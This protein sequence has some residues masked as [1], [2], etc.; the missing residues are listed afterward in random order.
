MTDEYIEKVKAEAT[1]ALDL[2]KE[3]AKSSH[4]TISMSVIKKME[5]SFN[6]GEKLL[7]LVEH[8]FHLRVWGDAY[9]DMK[10]VEELMQDKIEFG[11]SQT[12]MWG[13]WS[14]T[15][16]YI[17]QPLKKLAYHLLAQQ[18]EDEQKD[19]NK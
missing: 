12:Q 2:L 3:I 16:D 10:V 7:E 13:N 8:Y 9:A 15:L 18:K 17:K 14:K 11:K 1:Q 4:R 5:N 19:T 6:N